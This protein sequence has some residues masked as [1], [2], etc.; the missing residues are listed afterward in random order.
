MTNKERVLKFYD[1]V[2]NAHDLSRLDAYMRADYKQH[3]S[4]AADGREGFRAFAERFFRLDPHMDVYYAVAE[5]DLV[6]VYFSC[7][8]GNGTVNKVFDMYRMEDG[9]LAEH[10]DSVEHGIDVAAITAAN[11]NGPF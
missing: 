6:V 7:T 9:M 10:W 2:F 11:G 4:A 3:S 5:G 8:L 1:E